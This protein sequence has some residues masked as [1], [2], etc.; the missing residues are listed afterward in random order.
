MQECF[1]KKSAVDNGRDNFLSADSA[2]KKVS[3]RLRALRVEAGVTQR[4]MAVVC[5]CSYQQYQKM[6]QGKNRIT[7]GRLYLLARHLGVPVETFYSAEAG[8]QDV[9]EYVLRRVQQ[10]TGSQQRVLYAFMRH[11]GLFT[12]NAF[13]A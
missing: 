13:K 7:A 1:T 12:K 6:E 10:A 11:S 8:Q 9:A 3:K 5:G 2:E 4:E